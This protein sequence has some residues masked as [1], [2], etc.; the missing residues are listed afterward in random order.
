MKIYSNRPIE[1][2]LWKGQQMLIAIN[3]KENP[4][5][6][7][8]D[9][10]KKFEADFTIVD[11]LTAEDAIY[12]FTRMTND[13][14][15]DQKVINNIEVDGKPAI[16]TKPEYA[17]I[18]TTFF[19]PLP[20]SGELKKGAIYSHDN[21][22]VMVVQPHAR[23][24]YT[25]EQTPDLFSFWRNNTDNLNWIEGEK[26]EVGWKRMYNGKQYEVV[27]AHQT[28]FTWN[29]KLTISVLWN[30]VIVVIPDIKPPQWVS[31]NWGNYT[32]G[33]Q[34]FD[35]GKVWEVIG[36]THTW[37]QPAIDGNGAISWKFVK[38]WI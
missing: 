35:S 22:A 36:L 1:S 17:K 20:N 3:Q 8:D 12:A 32:M 24:I 29:P 10:G 33:Y 25:P 9:E 18:E 16:E 23:T 14:E 37:I 26:V 11:S 13:V 19:E 21:G 5:I 30:E 4:V 31:A 7:E 28:Q 27:Q 6:S 34:V 15:L 2:Q 38:D